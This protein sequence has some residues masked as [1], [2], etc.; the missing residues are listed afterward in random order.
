MSDTINYGQLVQKAFRGVM[1]DALSEVAE[2]GLPGE[3]YFYVTF[4]TTHPGVD[5]SDALMERYPEEMMVVMQEW[6]ENLAVMND[7]FT[8]TLNFDNVPEPIV[9]PFDAV[10]SFA[11]PSENFGLQ[12]DGHETEAEAEEPDEAPHDAEIVSLDTF[13]KH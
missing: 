13:R 11:D 6:F 1:I 10:K 12:F 2:N 5:M 8:V 4:D 3:H 7:R 9:I